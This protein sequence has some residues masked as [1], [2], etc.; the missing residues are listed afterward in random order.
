MVSEEVTRFFASLAKQGR[1]AEGVHGQRRSPRP[2]AGDRATSSCKPLP[3]D[4]SL[5]CRSLNSSSVERAR[6]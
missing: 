1:V 6:T 5:Y 3:P 2:T 4:A